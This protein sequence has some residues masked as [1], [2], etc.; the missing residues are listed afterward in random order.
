[1]KTRTILILLTFVAI[2]AYQDYH[3][4]ARKKMLRV[5]DK[6]ISVD[7]DTLGLAVYDTTLREFRYQENR[8]TD[9]VGD[10]RI[11]DASNYFT[12]CVYHHNEDTLILDFGAGS[13]WKNE[14]VLKIVV[15][16]ISTIYM[17]FRYLF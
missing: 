15:P 7:Y 17:E 2:F 5:R 8:Y 10:F 1:M 3:C 13:E 16:L 9:E 11:Y 6:V 4:F 12:Q 14:M